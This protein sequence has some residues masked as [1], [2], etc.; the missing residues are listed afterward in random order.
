MPSPKDKTPRIYKRKPNAVLADDFCDPDAYAIGWT[1]RQMGGSR[2]PPKYGKRRNGADLI[3]R[4]Q[5]GWD[6]ADAHIANVDV[7][8]KR[9]KP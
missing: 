6:A 4:W 8:A 9:I 3:T 2:C 7:V 1:R 5:A